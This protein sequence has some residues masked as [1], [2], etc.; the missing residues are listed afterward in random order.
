M[1]EQL[2]PADHRQGGARSPG[3]R[4]K[5]QLEY[6]IFKK[7][8]RVMEED[9]TDSY[10][11]LLLGAESF[12]DFLCRLEVINDIVKYDNNLMDTLAAIRQGIETAKSELEASKSEQDANKKELLAYQEDLEASY[13]EQTD[14]LATLE[15]R[16]RRVRKGLRG[17]CGGPGRGAEGESPR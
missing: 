12:S 7:R 8:V 16:H 6:E 9:G 5:E 3:R 14:Y 13:K 2:Y 10:V 4:R 15:K 17:V 1:I 11:T